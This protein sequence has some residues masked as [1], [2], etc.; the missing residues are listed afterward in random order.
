MDGSGQLLHRKEGVTQGDTLA[1]IAYGIGTLLIICELRSTHP[2]VTQP[3][4]ADDA[5]AGGK[6]VDFQDHMRDM[7]VWEP[8]QG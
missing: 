7:M 4:F 6:L 1:T 8:P 5:S 3:W 2:H